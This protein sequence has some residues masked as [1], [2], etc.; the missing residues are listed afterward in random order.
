[1]ME[2]DLEINNC[3]YHVGEV[4][5]LIG[6]TS[7]GITKIESA[8]ISMWEVSKL[9]SLHHNILVKILIS[10]LCSVI[11]LISAFHLHLFRAIL[12]CF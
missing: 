3:E 1:M 4:N 8:G 6:K 9:K 2:E 11:L 12:P 7:L 5:S 10:M